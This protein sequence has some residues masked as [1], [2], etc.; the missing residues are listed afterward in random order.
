MNQYNSYLIKRL[1]SDYNRSMFRKCLDQDVLFLR[2][3][4]K[5]SIDNQS[6]SSFIITQVLKACTQLGNLQYALDIH[7]LFLSDIQNNTYILA[8]LIHLCS[9]FDQK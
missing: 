5:H 6:F 8:S 3:F 9:E 4:A 1:L 7:H 2:R